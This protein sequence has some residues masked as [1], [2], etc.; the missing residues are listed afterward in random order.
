MAGAR[1][2]PAGVA[3]MTA[4]GAAIPDVATV[5]VTRAAFGGTA[6]GESRVAWKLL[7]SVRACQEESVYGI[8]S[9]M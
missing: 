5:E 3:A 6:A 7:L 1:Y 2:R 9:L 4:A 8:G